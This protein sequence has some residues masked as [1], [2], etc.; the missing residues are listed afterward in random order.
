MAP[1]LCLGVQEGWCRRQEQFRPSRASGQRWALP[2]RTDTTQHRIMAS[3]AQS[4]PGTPQYSGTDQGLGMPR[5]T[6]SRKRRTG[7][8]RDV[9]GGDTATDGPGGRVRTPTERGAV[10]RC[11]PV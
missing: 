4:V 7:G 5:S 11:S 3:V 1:L 6:P 9:E 8:R 2:P 10:F